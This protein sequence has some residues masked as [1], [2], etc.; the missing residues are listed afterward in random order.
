MT[1]PSDSAHQPT[2]PDP[3]PP[4]ADGRGTVLLDLDGTLLDSVD[5]HAHAWADALSDFRMGVAPGRIRP[6]IG[7]GGDKVIPILTGLSAD[8]QDRRAIEARRG[9]IFRERYLPRVKA[10]PSVRALLTALR[11]RRLRLIVASSAV[12]PDL[13]AL[14]ERA[15]IAD[16]LDG[17]VSGDDVER[18]KPDSD[19]VTCALQRFGLPP[20]DAVFVGDTP[21][22]VEAARRAGVDTVALRSG[23]WADDALRGAIAIFDDPA[24]LLEHIEQ[25]FAE[26]E[27][28]ARTGPT[29]DQIMTRTVR[30]CQPGDSCAVAAGL[31]WDGDFGGVPVVHDGGER[32]IGF[33]TD[34]DACM[35]AWLQGRPLHEVPVGSAMQFDVHSCLPT[36]AVA[37]ALSIMRERRLRRLPVIDPGGRLVGLVSLA[38]CA[39]LIDDRVADPTWDPAFDL[40]R[41]LAAVSAPRRPRT[42]PEA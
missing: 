11:A 5:A 38:D 12:E 21:Y 27:R 24:D 18:S 25:V 15:D 31:M 33:I 16:L 29:V 40:V 30:T 14:V 8:S 6:L 36:H 35:A 20:E 17:C 19:L 10:F 2:Q 7:M 9:E 39:R 42:P 4:V 37:T 1:A 26:H 34:R 28:P 32:V 3:S 13:Q 22:D 23:G 41:T